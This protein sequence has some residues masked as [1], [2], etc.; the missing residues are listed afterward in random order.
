MAS[1]DVP[2]RL[3]NAVICVDGEYRSAAEPHVFAFDRGVLYGDGVYDS[4][5]V[6]E[7]R[8]LFVDRHLDRLENSLDAAGIDLSISMETLT[9]WIVGTLERSD[10]AHGGC[11]IVVT[12]GTGMQG[13]RN[14]AALGDPTVLVLPTPRTADE[15]SYGRKTTEAARIVSTRTVPADSID[16]KLKGLSYLENVLAQRELAGTDATAGIMLDHQGRVAEAFDA[17]VFVYD[18]ATLRTPGVAS[19]L[20]GITRQVV[21]SCAEEM[22]FDVTVGDI[23]PGEL[24]SSSDVFLTGTGVGLSHLT[25]INGRSLGSPSE[26]ILALGEQFRATAVDSEYVELDL[27]GTN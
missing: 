24:Y 9:E 15:M 5:P 3:A 16:P 19:A 20:S 7:G 21:I 26:R 13:M 17:N 18:G 22:G 23:T 2:D 14:A 27:D 4:I 6:V 10:V 1:H 12:R 8:A 11:R 25:E